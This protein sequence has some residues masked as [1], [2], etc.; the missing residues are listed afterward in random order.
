MFRIIAAAMVA[1]S[2][3]APLPAL[4]QD[5]LTVTSQ[6]GPEKPQSKFW[7]RFA[8]LVEAARPGIYKFNIV[9][10]GALG[11][12]KEEA[13]GVRLGSITGALSTV[14]NLTTWVPDGA[15][16]DLPFVFDGREHIMAAMKGPLG[17]QLRAAYRAEGFETPAFI[18]FGARHLLSDRPLTKPEDVK[19][20]TM[21]VLE[22]DLHIALWRYL[23]AEPTALPITET[24]TALGTGVVEAMDLTK[25]G[26]EALKLFE[27]APVLSETAHIWAIGVVY[28]DRNFWES[29]PEKDQALFEEAA[30]KAAAYFNTLAEEEQDEAM[31]RA[32]GQRAEMV[33]VDQGPWR[34]AVGPFVQDYVGTLSGSAA[35]ALRAIEAAR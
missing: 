25:S 10:N 34:E 23:G 22:S 30:Q 31:R 27:V 15:V 6:Y 17:K 2:L 18:I 29:L 26:Y 32:I 16:L 8:A 28:F 19:G 3:A 11:G 9:T 20:L 12:E 13:E 21:R 14:A 1:A 4:A 5:S 7:E 33:E 35:E 24:Y